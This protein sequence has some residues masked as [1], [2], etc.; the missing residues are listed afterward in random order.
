[1]A[2]MNDEMKMDAPSDPDITFSDWPGLLF[3]WCL[4]VVVFIQFFARYVLDSS[5]GW[6]EE[7]ARYLLIMVTFFGSISVVRRGAHISLEFVARMVPEA[8]ARYLAILS[9]LISAGFYAFLAFAAVELTGLIRLELASLPL[10]K[11]WI[12]VLIAISAA[13]MCFFS[14]QRLWKISREDGQ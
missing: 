14:L 2:T 9:E 8:V 6:T 11:S 3:L 7:V 10:P 1:M 13:A 12:Y 5:P 4:L